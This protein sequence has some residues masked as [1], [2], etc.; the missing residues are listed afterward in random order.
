VDD[1]VVFNAESGGFAVTGQNVVFV[2]KLNPD[3]T[4]AGPATGVFF[5]DADLNSA[6]MIF[7]VPMY[8]GAAPVPAGSVGYFVG[9]VTDSIENMLF[10][11]GAAR[12]NP[13]DGPYGFVEKKKGGKVSISQATV[14]N[15]KSSESGLLL[16]H[17]REARDEASILRAN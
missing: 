7:T 1:Y 11:P 5:G 10:T 8:T 6:N 12:F 13:V 14:P 2:G 16:L 15:T 17:R 4:S 3:G 9:A